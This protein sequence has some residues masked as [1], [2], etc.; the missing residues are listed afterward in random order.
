MIWGKKWDTERQLIR[1]KIQQQNMGFD[2]LKVA[3]D[4]HHI[5]P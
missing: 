5:T 1:M 3:L 2:L 4:D